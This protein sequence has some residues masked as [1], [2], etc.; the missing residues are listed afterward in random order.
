MLLMPFLSLLGIATLFAPSAAGSGGCVFGQ[1]A[2]PIGSLAI[3]GDIPNSLVTQN[4]NGET[5]TLN[6]RQLQ[7]A[8]AIVAV[9]KN[10]NVPARG[11]L[12]ALMAALTESSLRVLSNTAAYPGSA[13]IPNASL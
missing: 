3:N 13:S 11:Q 12:I 10:E 9:G 8:G 6:Q 2:T 4:S 5:V 1:D 7:R